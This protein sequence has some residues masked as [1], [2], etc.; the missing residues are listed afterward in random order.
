M[1]IQLPSQPSAA[2][3][4]GQRS[5]APGHRREAGGFTLIELMLAITLA[6]ILLAIAVP[7]YRDYVRR[8]Q[9]SVAIADIARIK[10]AIEKYRLNHNDALPASLADTSLGALV[11]PWR[12]PYVYAPF[13][14]MNGNGQK[15]K[16]RNLVPIN[17]EYD[18]YSS[19]PDGESVGPLTAKKSL[20]DV[21]MANDGAFI[22]KACDY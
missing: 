4:R 19:G 2:Q 18:L 6:S 17:S 9:Y 3:H 21:I 7:S 20:D 12:R 16:D 22:G 14:G 15:R 5:H 11:D 13:A 8:S 1:A 10:A